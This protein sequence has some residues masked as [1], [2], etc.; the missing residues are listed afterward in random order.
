MKAVLEVSIELQDTEWS[1]TYT[2]HDREIV[3][4]I[5]FDENRDYYF[6]RVMRDDDFG[7]AELIETSGGGVEN[8][9]D[10]I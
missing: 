3:R 1:F 9:E 2:N 10:F 5:V 8:R 7:K 4:A 6:V